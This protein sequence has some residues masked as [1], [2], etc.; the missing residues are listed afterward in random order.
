MLAEHQALIVLVAEM[1]LAPTAFAAATAAAAAQALFAV[2]LDKENELLLPALDQ[3]GMDLAAVLEGMHE[4]M[5]TEIAGHEAH[6]CGCGC[7]HDRAGQ[8]RPVPE[9]WL[10]AAPE[11]G[12]EEDPARPDGELDVRTLPHG[13]RHEIIFGRLQTLVPGRRW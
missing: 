7:G 3:A 9:T 6:G 8:D 4:V 11:E 12:P 10:G 1:A 5:A 13:Q 2:H